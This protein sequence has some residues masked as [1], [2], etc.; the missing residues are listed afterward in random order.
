MTADKP[1]RRMLRAFL[2]VIGGLIL[3]AG[4]LVVVVPTFDGS[5][6]LVENE[7]SALSTLRTI[8]QLRNEYNAA[9]AYTGFAM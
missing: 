4:L 6:R 1:P 3:M 8:I 5:Q 2:W 9:H 7:I